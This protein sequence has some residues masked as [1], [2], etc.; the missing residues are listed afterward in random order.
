MWLTG[1]SALSADWGEPCHVY[2]L[3]CRQESSS[4]AAG[5][6]PLLNQEDS[7][8][9]L[10]TITL[11]G[12]SPNVTVA[13]LTQDVMLWARL[14]GTLLC[15]V[16]ECSIPCPYSVNTTHFSTGTVRVVGE[17][18]LKAGSPGGRASG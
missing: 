5:P 9:L 16:S 3:M 17:V 18:E 6:S 13:P 11:L 14:V 10:R 15:W 4:Q 8:Q 12:S 2:Q 1:I 7:T